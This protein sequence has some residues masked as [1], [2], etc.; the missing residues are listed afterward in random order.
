M[1][2]LRELINIAQRHGCVVMDIKLTEPDETATWPYLKNEHGSVPLPEIAWHQEITMPVLRGFIKDLRLPPEDFGLT[3][4]D[5]GSS[6]TE[7]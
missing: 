1:T 3:E 2:N 4:E 6:T 7:S 5:L